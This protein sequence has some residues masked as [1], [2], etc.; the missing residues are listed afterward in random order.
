MTESGSAVESSLELPLSTASSSVRP[1]N[2]FAQASIPR[3]R[4]S[5]QSK[6]SLLP[7]MRGPARRSETAETADII[8]VSIAAGV[9]VFLALV[10][11]RPVCLMR[12]SRFKSV[13]DVA[14]HGSPPPLEMSWLVLIAVATAGCT[15]F[16]LMKQ[17]RVS[18]VSV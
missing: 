15:G 10:V 2:L 17:H 12:S 6:R 4:D 7:D 11:L 9:A 5:Y 3:P 8:T 13:E 18:P 14:N 16:L 1:D